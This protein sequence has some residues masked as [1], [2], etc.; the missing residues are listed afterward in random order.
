M[1]KLVKVFNAKAKQLR[2][3]RGSD[4]GQGVRRDTAG[5]AAGEQEK[6]AEFAP[7]QL[8]KTVQEQIKDFKVSRLLHCHCSILAV[9]VDVCM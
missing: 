1:Y 2:K 7:L 3:E 5:G 8:S 4:L 6:E 9:C